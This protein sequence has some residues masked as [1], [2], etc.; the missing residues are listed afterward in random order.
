MKRKC[1]ANQ[2]RILLERTF[3]CT[4]FVQTEHPFG[5]EFQFCMWT[6][7]ASEERRESWNNG[8]IRY[9]QTIFH[10]IRQTVRA[11]EF[12]RRWH[13]RLKPISN[14]VIIAAATLRG[15]SA[16]KSDC[17]SCIGMLCYKNKH[18]KWRTHVSPLQLK[19]H[20]SMLELTTMV[21]SNLIL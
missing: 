1:W 7:S 2:R 20:F 9:L 18:S 13:K 12:G 19:V 11:S 21:T 17:W 5:G 14:F 4:Y 8:F 6:R 10:P 15:K 16:G 3:T